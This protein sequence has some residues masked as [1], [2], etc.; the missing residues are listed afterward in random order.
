MEP[1]QAI[2]AASDFSENAR[3]AALRAA[4]ISREQ[5]M[6]GRLLH[7][8]EPALLDT[9]R[10]FA[11]L[12]EDRL[13][14]M[15]EQTGQSLKALADDIQQETGNALAPDLLDGQ[16][17]ETLAVYSDASTLVVIGAKG[18]HIVRDFLVGSTARRLL[19]KSR[20]PVLVVKQP[21][22]TLYRNILV[23]TDFSD[24]S[25]H[26]L[27]R[28]HQLF[29]DSQ[30]H[31]AHVAGALIDNRMTYAGVADNLLDECRKQSIS[32]A[33]AEMATFLQDAGIDKSQVN[34]MLDNGYPP[35]LLQ[36]MAGQVG[37]ELIVTGKKGQSAL[38]DKLLGGVSQHLLQEC[39]TDLLIQH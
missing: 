21:A 15:R 22:R 38:G 3:Q 35:L 29:P 36:Q 6:P 17:L 14:T 39:S 28:C 26:A 31:I 9:L 13:H 34:I 19:Y 12:S 37:A 2:I 30:L 5:K 24:Y 27:Q 25:L 23:A 8:V 18:S 4:L 32:K 7:V 33:E 11:G 20:G 16:I 10:R 1:L